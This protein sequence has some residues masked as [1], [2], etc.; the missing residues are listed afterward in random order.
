MNC[1]NFVVPIKDEL[2]VNTKVMMRTLCD[3]TQLEVEQSRLLVEMDTA[4]A[5]TERIIVKNKATVTD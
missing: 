4:V 5:L 1:I 3:A 2:I